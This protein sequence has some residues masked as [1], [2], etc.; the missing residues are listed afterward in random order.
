MASVIPSILRDCKPDGR[1]GTVTV[2][3]QA[4]TEVVVGVI[5]GIVAVPKVASG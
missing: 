3:P 1:G 2:A 5:Q 4:E